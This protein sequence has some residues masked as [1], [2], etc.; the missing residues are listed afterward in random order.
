MRLRLTRCTSRVLVICALA[1]VLAGCGS[2]DSS[3]DLTP[4]AIPAATV[5]GRQP[6]LLGPVLW[7]TGIDPSTG[8]PVDRVETFPRDAVSI[9]AA[10]DVRNLPAGGALTAAWDFNG[11]PVEAL[12]TTIEAGEARAAGWVN[13]RLDWVGQTWWPAGTLSIRI[14]ADSGEAVEGEVRIR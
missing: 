14:A 6:V 9:H 2:G 7:T 12:A 8:Q 1:V 5:A 3:S 11:S 4:S 13:F 10:V